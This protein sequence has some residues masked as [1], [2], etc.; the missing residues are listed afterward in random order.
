MKIEIACNNLQSCINAWKGGADR[1]ELF[2]N[3]H[4]GGCTP[5][6][7]LLK[8]VKELIPIPVYVMIR[9]RGGHF[10]YNEDEYE[11]MRSDINTCRVLAADGIVFGALNKKG[12]VD[13]ELCKK[14][15]EAWKHKPSTFHRA[16]DRS[17]DLDK[18]C[19]E[20]IDLGFERILTSGGQKTVDE[21]KEKIKL[22]QE[23]FGTKISIMP[24]S[25]VTVNNA[26][27]ISE[28]CGTNEIHATCKSSFTENDI[29]SNPI[30]NDSYMQSDLK[31]IEGL[32]AVF[33]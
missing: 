30:F 17:V 14:L 15:L 23:N 19:T 26:K 7:G 12:Q 13:I 2:E 9:P 31:E 20:I 18:S 1:I 28:F 25:G 6:F 4:D 16:F 3:L 27:M 22:L 21:G 29:E 8:K 5:S 24:G 11:I 32:R 33:L 10:V